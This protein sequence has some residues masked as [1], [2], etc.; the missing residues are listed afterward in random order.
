MSRDQDPL[1]P[2]ERALADAM[3]RAA[4]R[5]APPPRIDAAVL[6]SAR[7]ALAQDRQDA[8]RARRAR[9]RWPAAL[10]VAASLALAVGIAWQLRPGPDAELPA[11]AEGP[12]AAPAA[13]VAADQAAPAESRRTEAAAMPAPAPQQK[14]T[15]EATQ[16]APAPEPA[17]DA[18]RIRE[19]APPP[20]EPAREETAPPMPPPAPPA[21]PVPPQAAAAT[22]ATDAAASAASAAAPP[23]AETAIGRSRV[24]QQATARPAST[25]RTP[26]AVAT[27]ASPALPFEEVDED[28]DGGIVFDR[29]AL[30]DVPPATVDSPAIHRAWLDRIRE[31]RDAGELEAARDSLREYRRRY[32][33]QALPDDLDGL[34]DE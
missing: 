19:P 21:P 16:A 4:P 22:A 26:T 7:A 11:I 28:E 9:R 24:R 1:S 13:S 17:R 15:P 20:P 27:P 30:H 3:A 25:L 31:L 12:P 2:E 6:A 8:P 23:P 32:P 18:P 29:Q 33:D 34:L 10:G 5:R 14:A